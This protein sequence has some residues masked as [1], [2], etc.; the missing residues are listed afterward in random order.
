MQHANTDCSEV[1]PADYVIFDVTPGN[2]PFT[3]GAACYRDSRF[4]DGVRIARDKWMPPFK[5]PAFSE[6]AVSTAAR[7]PVE[8][9]MVRSIDHEAITDHFLAILIVPAAAALSVQQRARHTGIENQASV[10][11]FQFVQA[12]APATIA[13]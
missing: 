6:H 1:D 2:G 13:E 8:L 12:A 10:N 4:P 5:W 9:F 7:Q 11:V 3:D